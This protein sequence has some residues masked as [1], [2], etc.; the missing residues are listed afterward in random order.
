MRKGCR[1]SQAD[2]RLNV[3]GRSRISDFMSLSSL[4]SSFP[5]HAVTYEVQDISVALHITKFL[6]SQS[7]TL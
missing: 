7:D 6:V 4:S 2:L 3:I 5:R 1:R